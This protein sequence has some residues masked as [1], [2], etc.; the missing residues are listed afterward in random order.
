MNA[1]DTMLEQARTAPFIQEGNKYVLRVDDLLEYAGT[2]FGYEGGSTFSAVVWHG[3]R[4]W[5]SVQPGWLFHVEHDACGGD[6]REEEEELATLEEAQEKARE[7]LIDHIDDWCD[8]TDR[9]ITEMNSA[10]DEKARRES[11]EG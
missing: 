11:W 7:E 10:A 3:R 4:E 9:N 8:A 2:A 6:E 1:K 5:A